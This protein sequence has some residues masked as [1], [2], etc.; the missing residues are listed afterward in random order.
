MTNKI[1]ELLNQLVAKT[2]LYVVGVSSGTSMDGMDMALARISAGK[3]E[4]VD[5]HSLPYQKEV[6]SALL[7]S[8]NLSLQEVTELSRLVSES[9]FGAL[10]STYGNQRI[11][12]V[13][14]HGQTVYHHSMNRIKC[15]MQIGDP[16]YIAVNMG[17]LVIG[18]FRQKDL[19]LDGQGAPVLP[20][21][22]SVL[23]NSN[24][25]ASKNYKEPL[26]ILNLGGIANFT[27]LIGEEILGFDV[28]PANAPLD[29]LVRL[30][31]DKQLSF[32]EGGHL[33]RAGRINDSLLRY[34]I[35]RD[36]FVQRKPPK[37]T[38]FEMYGDE[39]ISDI[40]AYCDSK[41]MRFNDILRT[42][43]EFITW[44]IAENL[45]QF[46]PKPIS[47][48][49]VAG[50]GSSNTFLLEEIANKLPEIAVI[51]NEAFD[52]PS[53]A[54]EA[55]GFAVLAYEALMGRPT[56]VPSVTGASKR[57]ILGKFCLPF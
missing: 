16:D 37:S 49:V 41:P 48:L 47:T 8:P 43:V 11:D 31:T 18:D 4:M 6:K 55:L 30:F 39:F 45:R 27:L 54:R 15:S 7:R 13:G 24:V 9:F 19:A 29:R 23:F 1:I 51:T 44:S 36:V 28:G 33:A 46:S 56:S 32:D 20:Y 34:I 22:D 17:C 57:A 10:T 14:F 50:G 2:E 53:Q 12:L 5:F 26:G 38:G 35:D 40:L 25:L 52:V 42:M 3:V 21:A